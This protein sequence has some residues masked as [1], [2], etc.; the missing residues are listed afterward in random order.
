MNTILIEIR[1]VVNGE[2]SAQGLSTEKHFI[3][4]VGC[5]CQ[6]IVT[7][8]FITSMINKYECVPVHRSFS[9]TFLTKGQSVHTCKENNVVHVF[10]TVKF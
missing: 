3:S 1:V 9:F 10:L 5:Y 2:S 6:V 7:N 4:K 8:F